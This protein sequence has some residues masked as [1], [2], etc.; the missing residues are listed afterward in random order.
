VTIAS[1]GQPGAVDVSFTRP[2][3][4]YGVTKIWIAAD[5]KIYTAAYPAKGNFLRK[6]VRLHADGSVDQSFNP[7]FAENFSVTGGYVP[8]TWVTD[9]SWQMG[10]TVGDAMEREFSDE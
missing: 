8:G 7:G 2:G 9:S 4:L 10:Y 3:G 6:L 1:R 5:G